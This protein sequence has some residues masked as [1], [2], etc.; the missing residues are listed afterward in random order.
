MN[1]V[2]LTGRPRSGKSTLIQATVP[3]SCRL[4][5]FAV[6]RLT[7]QGETWAFR[8]LDLTDEPYITHLETIKEYEDI[9]IYMASPGKWKGNTTVFNGKGKSSLDRCLEAKQLVIMDELGIFER[10]ALDFQDS[11][12]KVLASKL[13]VLGVLKDKSSPFLDR[14]R[15]HP[16]VSILKFPSLQAQASLE[17]LVQE[18]VSDARLE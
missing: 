17:K 16:K 11:V 6:Q 18:V 4:G 15:C 12:F 10:D 7:K 3:K 9:A 5:G 8:L 13:P 1:K 14:V 2:L